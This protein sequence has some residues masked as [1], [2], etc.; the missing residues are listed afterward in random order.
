VVCIRVILIWD[1]RLIWGYWARHI[2]LRMAFETGQQVNHSHFSLPRVLH[3]AIKNFVV[4]HPL[5]DFL[6][7]G[8]V[9]SCI[10]YGIKC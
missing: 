1:D 10:F 2:F 7:R 8:K 9:W 6:E 4:V 5:M 3:S